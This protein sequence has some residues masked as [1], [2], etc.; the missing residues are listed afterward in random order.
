MSPY[1]ENMTL[2]KWKIRLVGYPGSNS[3]GIS[4]LSF[5][6]S[7][8]TTYLLVNVSKA[9][10]DYGNSIEKCHRLGYKTGDKWKGFPSISRLY[11]NTILCNSCDVICS[12]VKSKFGNEFQP[13]GFTWMNNISI[14]YMNNIR[15]LRS[16]NYDK[17]PMTSTAW[18]CFYCDLIKYEYK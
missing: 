17:I 14:Y 15:M 18:I 6:L 2:E 11:N 13:L 10:L 8:R 1:Y 12:Q 3:G 5:A 9:T 7:F 4:D 16:R